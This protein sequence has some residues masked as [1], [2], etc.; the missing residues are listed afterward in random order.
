MPVLEELLL[1]YGRIGAKYDDIVDALAHAINAAKESLTGDRLEGII[2]AKQ[3][4]EALYDLSLREGGVKEG[5]L[6]EAMLEKSEALI[7]LERR[8][9]HFLEVRN[10]DALNGR[11]DPWINKQITRLSKSIELVRK[12]EAG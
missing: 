12:Q 9:D 3:N 11:H 7:N 6:T 5:D 10:K 4:T 2:A 8:L 1:E